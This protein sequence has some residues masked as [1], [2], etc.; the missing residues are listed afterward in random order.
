MVRVASTSHL[1]RYAARIQLSACIMMNPSQ[2]NQPM[3]P[4]VVGKS[5]QALIGAIWLDT[6]GDLGELRRIL[7]ATDFWEEGG[8]EAD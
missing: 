5:T 1:S 8:L 6:D 4:S 7:H 3:S 2:W